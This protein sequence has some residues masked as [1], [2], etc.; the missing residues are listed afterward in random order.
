SGTGS[1]TSRTIGSDYCSAAA[2]NGKLAPPLESEVANHAWSRRARF[3]E[4]WDAID[5][6]R[7][8]VQRRAYLDEPG[9]RSRVT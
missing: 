4:V 6:M 3:V 1:A 8:L 7:R 9:A 2:S 5:R